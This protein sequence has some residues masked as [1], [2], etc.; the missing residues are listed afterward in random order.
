MIGRSR[1]DAG[2][3]EQQFVGG[4]HCSA[5]GA[6]GTGGEGRSRELLFP[7]LTSNDGWSLTCL[8]QLLSRSLSGNRRSP[9]YRLRAL[10]RR[11]NRSTGLF[12]HRGGTCRP[13]FITP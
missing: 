7:W 9:R 5:R 8:V 1:D 3:D 10:A 6:P 12:A 13:A 11:E 2:I 4:M